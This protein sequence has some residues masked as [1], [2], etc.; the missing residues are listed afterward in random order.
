MFNSKNFFKIYALNKI[1]RSPGFCF[2]IGKKNF[3]KKVSGNAKITQEILR[4]MSK[5]YN[6]TVPMDLDQHYGETQILENVSQISS[7]NVLYRNFKKISQSI[8][9]SF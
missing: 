4:F 8:K 2:E 7:Q 5:V 3:E 1:D 9:L 6:K